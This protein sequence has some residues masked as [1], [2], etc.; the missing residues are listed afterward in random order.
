MYYLQSVSYQKSI[1]LNIIL[2]PS[3]MTGSINLEY[4]SELWYPEIN[5]I[6]PY[7]YLPIYI[8]SEFLFIFESLPK[9]HFRKDSLFSELSWSLLEIFIL[10]KWPIWEKWI[11]RPWWGINT[12]RSYHLM[13]QGFRNN[14][15]ALRA[16]LKRGIPELRHPSMRGI[17]SNHFLHIIRP[18]NWEC[19]DIFLNF[20]RL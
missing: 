20:W 17:A 6:I 18:S 13:F 11:L 12:F 19:C 8:P 3:F 4:Q 15:P 1:S 16:P 5:N 14:H 9:K 7:H 10:R 2:F